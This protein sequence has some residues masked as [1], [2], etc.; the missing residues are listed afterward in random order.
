LPAEEGRQ[1]DEKRSIARRTT[2]FEEHAPDHLFLS[3]PAW[4]SFERSRS[5][6]TVTP[7]SLVLSGGLTRA[8][9]GER[10]AS[11]GATIT[12]PRS[13]TIKVTAR[14][15]RLTAVAEAGVWWLGSLTFGTG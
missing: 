11:R 6:A 2:R 8:T 4:K 13:P 7:G 14:H 1:S 15:F 5:E 12:A 3:A 9:I 10:G